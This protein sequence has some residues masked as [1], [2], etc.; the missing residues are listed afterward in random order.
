MISKPARAIVFLFLA[1]LSA[2]GWANPPAAGKPIIVVSPDRKVRAELI[3]NSGTL[4]YRITVDGK[5]VIAPSRLGIRSDNIELGQEVSLGKPARR[6][7]DERYRFFGAHSVAVNRANEA[8]VPVSSHGEAYFVDL[9]VANDGAGVRLRLPAKPGRKIQADRSSWKLEGDPVMW[10]DKFDPAYESPYHASSLSRLGTGALGL[11]ITAYTGGLYL[12]VAEAALKDY[13]DLSVKRGA[14][15]ALEGE[16]VADPDGWTTDDEVVQPWRVTIVARDL[17]S[18][19]NTTLVQ[20]LNPPP[21]PELAKADW[22]K[23][24]RSAWQ[25]MAIGAPRQDDQEQWVDWTSQL[26]FEYYLIDE[27]WTR[28]KDPW[29]TVASIVAYA[30]TRNVKVWIW[31][32]SREVKDPDARKAYFRKAADA[33]IV[34]VKIDFPAACN[35]WWSNWYIDTA[36][37]AAAFRLML[38]FHGAVKPTGTERTWPNVLTREGIRGHEYHITRYRRRLEADHDVILPFTRLVA[39]PGDY[40]PTVFEPKELQGNTWGHELAQPIVFTSPYLCYGG[41]PRDY[42]ANPAR[43]ILSA[44]PAVWD[45]T[46]VLSGSEPGKLIA[47]ARRSG[48]RWF[49]AAINGADA[50]TLD[51]PLDFL[52][53]GTWSATEL[54][55][56]EDKPEGWNRQ[57]ARVSEGERLKIKLA[58]RGGFVG[59]FS[60]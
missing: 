58:P 13:G 19:V 23:P 57:S 17:T 43:D 10:V 22:I 7:V 54:F 33:G 5:Q 48:D 56:A 46:R 44:I 49:V 14:D 36:R 2:L 34:G 4:A 9:H 47:M 24:G 3:W 38:D 39:G 45:E 59:Y 21:N 8:T 28:W 20:N 50:K 26:G 25:W 29:D 18:L 32:H 27:G 31:V 52:G 51:I 53:K 37:D 11:P 15:G 42:L 16:L 6:S 40:T 55:D 30:K 60:K 41:H 1:A 12:T 35:R